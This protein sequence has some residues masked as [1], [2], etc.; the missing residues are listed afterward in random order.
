MK[1]YYSRKFA[2]EYKKLPKNVKR[3]AEEREPVFRCNPFDP[4]L[5]THHLDGKLKEYLS[6]SLDYRYRII[7]EFDTKDSVW[8]HSI[9]THDIYD[10]FITKQR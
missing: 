6:F 4:S 9:G 2:R 3:L 8:F 7:F 1:I 5:R 10:L